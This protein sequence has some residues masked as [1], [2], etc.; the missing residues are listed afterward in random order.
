MSLTSPTIVARGQK[1]PTSVASCVSANGKPASVIKWDTRLTGDASV[2]E[3]R[4][5]NGTVTVSSTYVVAPSRETHK[6]KLTC[7]VTYRNE[8]IANSVVAIEGFDGNW[9]LNRQGV[10]L[11]CRAD[12]NPPVTMYQWKM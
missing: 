12:A 6:Q 4:H 1:R 9:Y 2:Q 10:Q 3:T 11:S 7:I 5:A 8:P